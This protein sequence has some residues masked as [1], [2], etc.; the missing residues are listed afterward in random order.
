MLGDAAAR[1]QGRA[2]GEGDV[3]AREGHTG[4][5]PSGAIGFS[6][7]RGGDVVG[8]HEVHFLGD[9][10]RLE[11]THKASSRMNFARGAVRAAAWLAGRPAGRYGLDEIFS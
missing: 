6:V 4:P 3:F 8:D 5:R 10:E 2:L 11:L 9:G 1:G 7:V